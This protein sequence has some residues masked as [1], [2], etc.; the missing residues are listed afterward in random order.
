EAAIQRGAAIVNDVFALQRDSQMAEVV[1]RAG[2]PVVLMHNNVSKPSQ[3]IVPDVERDLTQ[4][5]AIAQAAGIARDRIIIDPGIGFGKTREQNLELIR[6]LGE[7]RRRLGYP[8]LVGPSRKSFIGATLGL[9]VDQRVEGTAAAVALAIQAGA[10]IVRVHD[11][12]VMTRVARMADAIV[13]AS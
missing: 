4:S 10:D 12:E 8:V 5:I 13:R 3:A 2:V 7:L 1:A 11:V 6:R 9:D